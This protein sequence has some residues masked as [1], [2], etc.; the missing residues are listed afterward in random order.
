MS[1][2]RRHLSAAA[3]ALLCGGAIAACGSSGSSPTTAPKS[4]TGATAAREASKTPSQILADA[5]SALRKAHSAHIQGTLT[6]QSHPPQRMSISVDATTAHRFSMALRMNGVNMK[7]IVAAGK[8]YMKADHAFW[9]KTSGNASVASLFANR[10]ILA[11]GASVKQFTSAGV[12]FSPA[13]LAA[14]LATQAHGRLTIVGQTTIDHQAAVVVRDDGNAP[15]DQPST[16]AVAATAPHYPLRVTDTGKQRPGGPKTGPCSDSGPT[17]D[18]SV[19]LSQ[20]NDVAKI[21]APAHA[22]NLKSLEPDAIQ[23]TAPNT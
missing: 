5:A 14:C 18:G 15:G 7:V 4:S 22:I 11:P 13:Q 2:T 10:W 17:A 20:W 8:A 3:V 21:K 16:L 1:F 23:P 6:E 9:V 19:T 12:Q